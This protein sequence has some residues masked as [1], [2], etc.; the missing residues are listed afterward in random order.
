MH[1]IQQKYGKYV[2]L[3]QEIFIVIIQYYL[4]ISALIDLCLCGGRTVQQNRRETP[5][6]RYVGKTVQCIA[7]KKSYNEL[8]EKLA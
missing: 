1:L 6:G 3:H 8:A 2:C 4:L 7:S 5:V